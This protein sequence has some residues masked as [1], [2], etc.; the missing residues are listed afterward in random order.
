MHKEVKKKLEVQKRP[1][2][3]SE[4][5]SLQCGTKKLGV[6]SEEASMQSKE[7]QCRVK[8][9][10]RVKKLTV[11][12]EEGRSDAKRLAMQQEVEGLAGQR[13]SSVGQKEEQQGFAGKHAEQEVLPLRG[14]MLSEHEKLRRRGEDG[15]GHPAGVKG[16]EL[17][18]R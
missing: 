12:S 9:F 13:R 8:K 3:Q 18:T 10:Q 5:R 6:Q 11:Q 16:H 7:A 14:R 2:M 1:A 4:G 15:R 17:S